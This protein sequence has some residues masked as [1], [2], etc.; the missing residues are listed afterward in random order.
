MDGLNPG[1]PGIGLLA[2]AVAGPPS[3]EILLVCCGDVPSVGDGALRLVL[4][5]RELQHARTRTL[6]PDANL[7]AEGPFA[8][9]LVWPRPHLGKDFSTWCLARGALALRPGG[10]LWCAVRKA[11]GA[12]SLAERM[13]ALMGEVDVVARDRGHRL[14]RSRRTEAMDPARARAWVEAEYVIE[15]PAL[16]GLA[17]RS[18][19]GVFS[20]RELDAGTRVLIEHAER[21]AATPRG[22]IDL[23]C[24][25][26]P[27]SLWAGTRWPAAQVLAVDTNLRAVAMAQGN[28]S[29]HGL[30]ERVRVL[31]SDGL[32]RREEA[33]AMGL[34]TAVGLAVAPDLALVNPPTHAEPEV[35]GRFAEDLRQWLA[36]GGVAMVVVNRPGRMTEQLRRAG[37]VVEPFEYPGYHVLEARWPAA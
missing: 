21:R 14:L 4:D 6:P 1:D 15:D 3:R 33:E 10:S 18:G 26:G 25:V 28:A 9:A 17:L 12:D 29:R 27:L 37:A 30:A 8:H 23:G 24:G 36:P 34:R 19:P 32:P 13:V 35:L 11:K 2:G 22:V 7:E 20:R 31:P 16:P 5:L